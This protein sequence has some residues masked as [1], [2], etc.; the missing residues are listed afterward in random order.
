MQILQSP[1]FKVYAEPCI[2]LDY[3]NFKILKKP[4]APHISTKKFRYTRLR[5]KPVAHADTTTWASNE[6]A[7]VNN[8]DVEVLSSVRRGKVSKF[9]LD[10]TLHELFNFTLFVCFNRT[11]KGYL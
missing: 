11:V 6:H 9:C 1:R 2:N 10:S 4:S 3:C 5:N 8:E 7:L